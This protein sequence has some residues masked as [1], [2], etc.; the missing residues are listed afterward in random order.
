[1][2]VITSRDNAALKLA[3]KLRTKS[4]RDKE[5]AFLV[6]GEKLIAEARGA[7]LVVRTVLR[8]GTDVADVLFDEI[9]QTVTPQGVLAIV[10]KP[11]APIVIL[12]GG[13]AEVAGSGPLAVLVLD[14]IQDPGNVG[15]M[16]RT[17]YAAGFGAVWCVKGTADLWSDKVVRSAAGAL[18]RF[19]AGIREGLEAADVLQAARATGLRVVVCEAGGVDYSEVRLAGDG[20]GIALV[21]GNEGAGVS[22]ALREDADLTVGIPMREG[23]ESLNAAVSAALVMYEYRRQVLPDSRVCARE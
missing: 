3:R 21:V 2:D 18:F 11:K 10:E 1:M 5:G 6:E 12:R 9:A 16:I 8:R 20:G 4:G 22:A 19:A 17:A 7:G 14:R 23:A 15:T 13:E